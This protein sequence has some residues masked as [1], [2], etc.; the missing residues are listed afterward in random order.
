MCI[1]SRYKLTIVSILFILV[2]GI[3]LLGSARLV[4]H[5]VGPSLTLSAEPGGTS[6]TPTL[7]CGV[8]SVVTSPNPTRKYD[9]L[10]GVTAV[11]ANDVWAVGASATIS[12]RIDQTLIEHWN[13]ATWSVVPSPNVGTNNNVLN[14]LTRVP[15]G[16]M[17]AVGYYVSDNGIQTLTEHWDG[18]VWS[19]VPSPNIGISN[20]LYGVA[21]VPGTSELWAAGYSVDSNN[22][23]QTLIEHWDGAAWSVIPSPNAGTSGSILRRITALSTNN[24][25][26][27]GYSNASTTSQTLIEHW[28]GTSWLVVPSPNADRSNNYLLGLTPIS[29]SDIWAVGYYHTGKGNRT[30]TEH[31]DGTLW[32]VVSSPNAGSITNVL[33]G[34]T[35]I[36]T[37]DIWAVGYYNNP[38]LQALIEHWDG[39]SWSIVPSPNPGRRNALAGVSRV[40]GTSQVW[41]VGDTYNPRA[42]V[43][44]TLTEFYC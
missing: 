11:S 31:W 3:T 6:A 19:V 1:S 10:N 22:V 4:T 42:G 18:A 34:V 44:Q 15:A 16:D 12:S 21:W 9:S 14:G 5:A 13:G 37:S 32:H 38:R 23:F 41:A 24:V 39:T 40:P 7:N 33:S 17:W 36:S 27:V 2:L 20:I 25:W 35:M 26:A 28:N 29:A 43:N 8:W 30:L